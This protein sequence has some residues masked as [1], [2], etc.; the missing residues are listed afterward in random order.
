MSNSYFRFKEFTVQQD[1]CAMKITTD[2][3]LQGAWTPLPTA[4][5]TVLDIGTGT[6]LLALMLAQRNPAMHIDA[7]ELDAEAAM[8]A[9]ENAAASP[10]ANRI[11]VLQ[12]DVSAYAFT[13]KY[14]VVITNPP[15]FNSSLLGPDARRNSARH[16]HSLSYP[17]LLQAVDGC[18][19][20]GG[21]LSI[22]LPVAEFA[23]WQQHCAANGWYNVG[24]LHICHRPGAAAKRIIGLF[25]RQDTPIAS[26]EELTIY[27][28]D[29]AYSADFS[30]LLGPYYLAL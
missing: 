16:T 4:A 22:L 8:Q 12:G 21:Y 15:F 17:A 6:G 1:R 27:N 11:T 24:Q 5:A 30:R 26:S 28:T 19:A 3:C 20:P 29:G 2:A 25:S 18:L 10:W 14:D 7:I 9:A 13:K 23:I